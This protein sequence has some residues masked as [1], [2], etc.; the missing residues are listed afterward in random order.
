[1]PALA[2]RRLAAAIGFAMDWTTLP[3]GTSLHLR[4][5]KPRS[6]ERGSASCIGCT[7]AGGSPAIP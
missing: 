7:I 5:T 1:M 6:A 3:K 2:G 4:Q